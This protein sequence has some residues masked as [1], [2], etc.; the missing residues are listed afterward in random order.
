MSQGQEGADPS[1]EAL[2]SSIYNQMLNDRGNPES[3]QMKAHLKHVI[4]EAMTSITKMMYCTAMVESTPAGPEQDHY[5]QGAVAFGHEFVR[6]ITDYM[7]GPNEAIMLIT[8][9]CGINVH[10]MMT[11]RGFPDDILGYVAWAN[12]PAGKERIRNEAYSKGIMLDLGK[13]VAP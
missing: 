2:A 13:D 12:S 7:T 6:R 9:L 3:D 8:Q 10:A 11:E 1:Y 4:A 5:K